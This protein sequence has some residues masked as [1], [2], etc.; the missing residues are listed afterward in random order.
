MRRSHSSSFEGKYG[1]WSCE[2][3]G[4]EQPGFK[5]GGALEPRIWQ[6]KSWYSC[7]HDLLGTMVSCETVQGGREVPQLRFPLSKTIRCG[8]C[9]ALEFAK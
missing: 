7:I 6:M 1:V 8:A 4:I 2:N 5:R 3:A 9:H